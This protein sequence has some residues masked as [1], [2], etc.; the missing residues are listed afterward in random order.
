MIPPSTISV[1]MVMRYLLQD[2]PVQSNV[3]TFHLVVSMMMM[4]NP[5]ESLNV[6]MREGERE[7]GGRGSEGGRGREGGREG[8]R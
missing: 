6:Y 3:L 4:M 1:S 8:E 2:L 5:C 7:E